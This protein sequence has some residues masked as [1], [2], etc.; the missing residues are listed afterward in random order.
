MNFEIYYINFKNFELEDVEIQLQ[1]LDTLSDPPGDTTRI[2]IEA[3]DEALPPAVME[4]VNTDDN[5]TTSIKPKR[6]NI[7]FNSG[8][9]DVDGVDEVVDVETFSD[10]GDDRYLV[11]LQIG[12]KFPFLGNMVLDDNSEPFQPRPNQVR[13]SAADGLNSLK[14]IELDDDGELPLGHYSIID[15]IFMCLKDLH[16]IAGGIKV[17]MNLYEE[18]TDPV[19]SHAWIDTYVDALT[20]EKDVDSR[21]DKFT[22]LQ[23]IL[24]AFGCFIAHDDAGWWIIR[25]DE[26]DVIGTSVLMHRCATFLEGGTFTGYTSV[27]LTKHIAHD[28][29]AEYEGYFLS[30]NTAQRRFQAKAG[31]VRHIYKLQQPKEVPCNAKF[32]RGEL[33]I[34]V[35]PNAYIPECW[36]LRR[37]WPGDYEA[38]TITMRIAVEYDANDYEIER[39]LYLTPTSGT[40]VDDP[41]EYAECEPIEMHEKDKF[42]LSINWKLSTFTPGAF[43]SQHSLMRVRLHGDD[44]SDW[45]LGNENIN[46]DTT[47]LKW[48]DT[49]NFTANLSAGDRDID[50]TLIEEQEWQSIDLGESP[51]LPVDGKVYIMLEQFNQTNSAND[52][53]TIHYSDLRF[54]YYPYI[55]GT[56]HSIESQEVKVTADN[57]SRRTIE[58]EM[59]ISDSPKKLLKGALK[60]FDGSNYVLTGN[61]NF[62]NELLGLTDQ[63]LAK[64]VVFA[65]WNQFRKTRTVIESDIQGINNDESVPGLIHRWKI[66]HASEGDKQFML[67][68]FRNM[69]LRT[70]GW[71]GV[72][73]EMSD[74][75]GDRNYD[76]TFSFKYIQ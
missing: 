8:E 35:F 23:K 63:R 64:F 42:E 3:S 19:T 9:Y 16:G 45:L 7:G 34:L 60:K 33:D 36:T 13:L 46:D 53:M 50:T 6:L 29:E 52:N 44:G 41:P 56:Y 25:W 4:S 5:K 70:C 47:P 48:W 49:T 39:Y 31:E 18:D 67:T 43:A 55:N 54:T 68:S 26:Y 62:Y 69:N 10:G 15:Y 17:I 1:D 32:T 37:G 22:V 74:L 20:F 24:D 58:H 65:W 59:F 66:H 73:V 61:W 11:R 38:T 51:P 71:L 28:Q 14:N 30:Q 75:D 12:D 72:F 21:E 76:D 2:D 40:G 57:G 27:D